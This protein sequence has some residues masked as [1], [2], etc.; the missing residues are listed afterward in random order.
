ML[1][2]K[3]IENN[4]CKT[5]IAIKGACLSLIKR[6]FRTKTFVHLK[7]TSAMKR[8]PATR[9]MHWKIYLRE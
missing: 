1:N 7:D 8:C 3:N 9:G 2:V 6:K 5:I 4:V